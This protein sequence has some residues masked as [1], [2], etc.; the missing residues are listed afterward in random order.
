MRPVGLSRTLKDNS[1]K[2][3]HMRDEWTK[4][5]KIGRRK[6]EWVVTEG[7]GGSRIGLWKKV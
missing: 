1:N 2:H 6:Q 4:G 5:K 7:P 3:P